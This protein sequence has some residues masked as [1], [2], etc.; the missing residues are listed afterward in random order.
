MFFYTIIKAMD[1]SSDNIRKKHDKIC[2]SNAE[3]FK[4]WQIS[5]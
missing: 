5:V 3:V 2:F 1:V 4:Y